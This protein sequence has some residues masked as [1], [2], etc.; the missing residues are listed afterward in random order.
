MRKSA[1]I[2]GITPDQ[3]LGNTAVE[4]RT[5]RAVENVVPA[6][7]EL[8]RLRERCDPHGLIL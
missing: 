5:G 1:H 8:T 2:S 6:G 3:I 4:I 7:T